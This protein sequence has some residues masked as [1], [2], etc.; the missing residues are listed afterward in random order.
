MISKKCFALVLLILTAAPSWSADTIEANASTNGALTLSAH[1]KPIC[2]FVVGAFNENWQSVSA[3]AAPEKK[4]SIKMPSGVVITGEAAFSERIP[5][6][7]TVEGVTKSPMAVRA[8][9]TFTPSADVKLA[10]LNVT[11][12]FPVAM[13]VGTNWETRKWQGAVVKGVFPMEHKDTGLHT[14][15]SNSLTLHPNNGPSLE[16]EFED[17]VEVLL[18]DNRQWNTQSFSLRIGRGG[19]F[20]KGEP[21]TIEFFVKAVG[22]PIKLIQDG[23]VTITAGPDWIPLKTELDIEAGSALDFSGMGMT[24]APAGKYGR[25]ICRDDGQFVFENDKKTPRRFYGVNLCFSG[26]YMTH[27]EADKLADRFSRLGYN[28]VRIHHYEG[29]LT[30]GKKSTELNDEKIDQLD[31]LLAALGKRGIYVTTDLFV[32]RPIPY[33]DVGIDKPGNV[34]MDDFKIMI[35]ARPVAYE[36]WKA[37]ATTLLTHVNKYTGK[38]YADDPILAWLSMINEGN[39]GN[40][41]K[42]MQGIPEWKTL[43]NEW[44]AKKY[45]T[46]DELAK[47]W[48]DQMKADED[49]SKGNVATPN[50]VYA[51]NARARDEI[52]F[53][54]EKEREMVLKMKD[55]LH[56]EIHCGALITN[57]N[58]WTNFATDQYKREV[59]DYIDDHFYVDHPKFLQGDWRLPS[60]CDN[61]SPIA[62]GASG[63][64]TCA[65]TRIFGKPFT[66]TEY[67]FSGPGRFRGVGGILTG[68]MGSLQ[69]WSGIWRFG[70]AHDHSKLFSPVRMDYFDMVGD[71]LGQAAERASLCLFLRGDMKMAPHSAVIQMN[72]DELKNPPAKIPKLA[73]SWH[74]AAWI[75]RIGTSVSNE[76]RSKDDL[77]MLSR[78]N[79]LE[80]NM[81]YAYGA[82]SEEVRSAIQTFGAITK[83]NPSDPAKNIY[84]S[85]TGEITIDA[86]KDKMTLNTP[87]TI[88]GYA[89]AGETITGNGVSITIEGADATAWISSLDKEPIKTSKRLLV[90]HLTDLQNTEIKYAESARKTLLDWGK[91]PHLVRNGKA[92]LSVELPGNVQYDVWALSTGG[93]RLGK[94]DATSNGGTLKFTANVNGNPDEGAR[95][96][97]EIVAK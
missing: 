46:R 32:S 2:S 1:D 48:G 81:S 7:G 29:E 94:V 42:Q 90:T 77:P 25:V 35:P 17:N 54:G 86:P 15:K 28:A 70:Y 19:S 64:R 95:M 34:G 56:N 67:N 16:I 44:L 51:G 47:A 76:N 93:K 60:F 74:W 20:K 24:E 87:K 53:L 91:L 62:S 55:F 39:F 66:I 38:R 22:T 33:K 85:E 78:M 13:L 50:N 43:W 26:Q 97:Y 68:A 59:Y 88:G 12:D 18:Q 41:T 8:S 92:T 3:V 63:G 36:N 71:P 79:F 96:L 45:A 30:R 49:A 31:Y 89:K 84:H 73:A 27:D 83:D 80:M 6:K 10:S 4:F 52:L 5:I 69:G 21:I 37:F 23:P 40:F 14:S 72:V 11:A 58:A 57:S 65:F 82:K 75:L 61:T 9:Y